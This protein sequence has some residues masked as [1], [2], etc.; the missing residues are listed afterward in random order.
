MTP[1]LRRRR[2]AGLA[3]LPVALGLVSCGIGSANEDEVRASAVYAEVIGWLVADTGRMDPEEPMAVFV[4]PRG[5]GAGISL[6]VQTEVIEETKDVAD[7]RFLDER[8][9]GLVDEDGVVG[10]KDDGILIRLGPVIEDDRHVELDVDIWETV[11]TFTEVRFELR[12]SGDVWSVQGPPEAI[13]G[14]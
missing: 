9:E 5:E 14:G 13:E 1:G 12:R 10:V 3:A 6:D 2:R 7:V 11:D 8:A 4:E